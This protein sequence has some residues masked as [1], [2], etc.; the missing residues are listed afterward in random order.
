MLNNNE[1]MGGRSLANAPS[2]VERSQV[3][4]EQPGVEFAPCLFSE[5]VVIF[6]AVRDVSPSVIDA[7]EMGVCCDRGMAP[8]RLTLTVIPLPIE[9]GMVMLGFVVFARDCCKGTR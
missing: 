2:I 8:Q 1:E 5:N 6:S 3:L 9:R 4:S 7:P